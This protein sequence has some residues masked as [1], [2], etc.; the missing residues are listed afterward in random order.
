MKVKIGKHSF[1]R[2]LPR[3]VSIIIESSFDLPE[4]FVFDVRPMDE[5]SEEEVIIEKKKAGPTLPDYYLMYPEVTHLTKREY[6]IFHVLMTAKGVVPL[7]RFGLANDNLV[8]AH[9]VKIRRKLY[10]HYEIRTFKGFGYQIKK[11]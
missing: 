5:L 1:L 7:H 3:K 6:D 4:S 2:Q 8:S 10:G 11:L 9:M